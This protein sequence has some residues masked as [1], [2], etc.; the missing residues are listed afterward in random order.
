VPDLESISFSRFEDDVSY[1][2]S[3]LENKSSSDEK[4]FSGFEEDLPFS[5]LEN[6][7]SLEDIPFSDFEGNLS[8]STPS[9]ENRASLEMTLSCFKMGVSVPLPGFDNSALQEIYFSGFEEDISFSAPGLE[10]KSSEEMA[11]SDSGRDDS[12][13]KSFPL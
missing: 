10:N 9:L 8:V 6:N 5:M 12:T 4:S 13:G 2:I 11:F 3:E 7:S 1:Y